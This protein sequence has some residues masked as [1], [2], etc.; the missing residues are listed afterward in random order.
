MLLRLVIVS[1]VCAALSAAGGSAYRVTLAAPV[2]ATAGVPLTAVVR[3]S[4]VP[5]PSTV[6]VVATRQGARR[7]FAA[8]G[9]KGTYRARVVLTGVGQWTLTAR[10]AGQSGRAS[11]QV[12]VVPP[13]ARHP[14]AVVVDSRGRVFVADGASRR[15]LQLDAS[16]GRL[17]VHATGLDEPTGLA[18]A[19]G[20]LYVADFNAGLV[21]RIGADGRV[22]TLARLPQVTS[23]AA[24]SQS[25]Y[26]V[27][28]AGTLARISP[29]GA[30]V[31][32]PV[33]GGLDRPHGVAIGLDGRLLVAEDSRRVRRIDPAT[34]QAEPVVDGVDTNKIA[35]ARDGALFLAGAT[36]TGGSLRRL[37]PGG[38][39][40]VLLDDLR[41]SDVA[42]LPDGNLVATTVEPGAVYRVDARS[43]TR[44]KLVG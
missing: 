19:A 43:G 6:S 22:T 9:V 1:L 36:L 4:P 11:R 16:T 20:V 5:R 44:T 37:E 8:S 33:P 17:R 15:I 29:L 14:Y 3:V 12:R 10:V 38:R 24:A 40:S 34:G 26:A 35:V 41:V 25:V 28:L 30:I 27:T 23:V 42:V 31:R 39:P 18:A 32:I 2:T 7:T 21:R 13:T